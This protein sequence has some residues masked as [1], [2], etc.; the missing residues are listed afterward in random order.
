MKK[1]RK[2]EEEVPGGEASF[3]TPEAAV[4]AGRNIGFCMAVLPV[5]GT[6]PGTRLKS[7]RSGGRL[8]LDDVSQSRQPVNSQ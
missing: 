1:K 8:L 7:Q 2:E 3:Y 4:G 6:C 5:T